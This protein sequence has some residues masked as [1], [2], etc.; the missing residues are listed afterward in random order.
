MNPQRYLLKV[1]LTAALSTLGMIPSAHARHGELPNRIPEPAPYVL[2]E[3]T[4]FPPPW[5]NKWITNNDVG[6]CASCHPRVFGEWNGSMKANAWRDPGWRGAFLLVARATATD[7]NC[8]I[9]NPPD[10]TARSAL[11]PFAN[12]TTC[13]STFNTGT[14]TVTTSGSGSLMDDFCARC[15]MPS[16]YLDQVPTAN[17]TTDSPSGVQHGLVKSTF[18]PTSDNGTGIAYA[19][20]TSLSRNTKSGQLGIFCSVCHT[21]GD[22]RHTPYRNF[23]KS[24]T[25]YIAANG[26]GSRASLLPLG[27]RD[28]LAVAAPS[29]PNLGYGVGAGAYRLSPHAI[30]YPERFG[31]LSYDTYT[32]TVDPY[33]GDVFN[34]TFYYQKGQFSGDHLG[35]F[36]AKYERSEFCGAC[37]DVTNPLTIKNTKGKWAGGFPI[38]RTYT[39]WLQ[40]RYADRPGNTKFDPN[41]KRDCQTCHMQQ[42]FGQPGTAKTLYVGTTPIA[43]LTGQVCNMMMAPTRPAYYTHH[44]VG[45]NAYVSQMIGATAYSGSGGMGGGGMGGGGSSGMSGGNP[46]AGS[47]GTSG[48]VQPWPELSSASFSSSDKNSKYYNAYFNNANKGNPTHHARMAWDRLRSALTMTLSGPT[49]AAAGT[50]QPLTLKV[51]NEGSGHDFPTGFPEGRNAWVAIRAFD[52]KTGI[53]LNITDSYWG[54]TSLGVGYLTTS[55]IYDMI[56]QMPKHAVNCNY[57]MPVGSPDP[58][59][60]QFRAVASLGD[61]CPTLDLPYATAVNMVVDANNMPIDANGVVI[62][63][64]NPNGLPRYIDVDGDGDL[65]D[66]SFLLDSR[67]SPLPNAQATL[68]LNRYSVVIP[69][70]TQGPVAVTAA[71]YYQSFEAQVSLKFLGNLADIDED[72]VLEPCTLK[73]ACDGRTPKTEPAVVEGAPPVPSVVKSWVINIT[74][75]SDTLKPTVKKMY[76]PAN[77]TT[78]YVDVVPKVTFSEPVK[79]VESKFVLTNSSGVTI[80]ASVSQISDG[81]YAIFPNGVFLVAGATYIAKINTGVCDL[82]NN[83]TTTATSWSF[84]IDSGNGTGDTSIPLGF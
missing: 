46:N 64:N 26:T 52:T 70:G 69:A 81:T 19:A 24:G 38:E 28:M 63:K 14:G 18:D 1:S 8:D 44:F 32:S 62:D 34:I 47:G 20:V 4:A 7:G 3:A 23:D 5:E 10:G 54:R 49:S 59:A 36:S 6:A 57:K 61:N 84:K 37:H 33:V 76:P 56:F 48:N 65:F 35:Y 60:Y 67:L 16:N 71:V 73:G 82:N 39:E 12:G 13:T 83:C 66:D 72:R 58:Y 75:Q 50:T 68:N 80:P 17:V 22:S 11:N 30:G 41:F 29:K 2:S 21:M 42:D 15:H 9:P 77:H 31:P 45:A 55:E 40:S 51:V 78:A 25:E 53:E 27:Q 74:G 79:N 43:P